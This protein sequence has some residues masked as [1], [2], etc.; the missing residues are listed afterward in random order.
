MLVRHSESGG[1]T[2]NIQSADFFLWINAA[3]ENIR[4]PCLLKIQSQIKFRQSDYDGPTLS[5]CWHCVGDACPAFRHRWPDAVSANKRLWSEGELM[6]GHCSRIRRKNVSSLSLVLIQYCVELQWWFQWW[7]QI[8]MLLV[9]AVVAAV[10]P[11]NTRHSP[12]VGWM[13]GQRRRRWPN[14]KPTLHECVF[15]WKTLC[16]TLSLISRQKNRCPLTE[17][18]GDGGSSGRNTFFFSFLENI[19]V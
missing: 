2:I 4:L 17:D 5:Q 18:L 16:Y 1:P 14:I 13:V 12:N 15:M 6:L 10:A 8:E 7:F 9:C 3:K 19:E 11:S